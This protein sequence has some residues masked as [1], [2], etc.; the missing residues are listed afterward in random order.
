M[1]PTL[2]INSQHLNVEKEVLEKQKKGFT[3]TLHGNNYVIYRNPSD[4]TNPKERF[5]FS[6]IK[7]VNT[8]FNIDRNIKMKN[9]PD[10]MVFIKMPSNKVVSTTISLHMGLQCTFNC[11]VYPVAAYMRYIKS[12][13]IVGTVVQ[14]LEKKKGFTQRFQV[15]A[16]V[17]GSVSG[18]FF[19]CEASLEVTTGFEYEST[20]QSETTET[21]QQTLTQGSYIVYQNV[22]VYAYVIQVGS[23]YVPLINSENPGIDL[24]WVPS[25]NASVMFV[26]INRDDPFTLQYSDNT[27]EPVE[28]DTLIEYL[29]LPRLI[30]FIFEPEPPQSLNPQLQRLSTQNYET[31]LPPFFLLLLITFPIK[32]CFEIPIEFEID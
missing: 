31:L 26:P 7:T 5:D 6:K 30:I 23:P 16:N 22:L 9:P 27:N 12:Y 32:H 4:S 13:P 11:D 17:K 2:E 8:N 24:R 29:P 10:A 3:Q 1:D 14:T 25:L 15:S 18:G 28:Y 19:G 20:V 21:W